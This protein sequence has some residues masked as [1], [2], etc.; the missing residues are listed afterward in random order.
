MEAEEK[1]Q[2][3]IP[4]IDLRGLDRTQSGSQLWDS[5]RSEV[6]AAMEMYGCFEAVFDRASEELKEALFGKAMVDLFGLPLETKQSN[7]SAKPYLGYIG[8]IPGMDYESLRVE[9]APNLESVEKFARLL[10]PKGNP[11]FCNTVCTYAKHLQELEQMIGRMVLQ[12]MGL[13]KHYVSHIESLEYS[14]RLS[15]YGV[16]LDQET[17]I[18]MR[19]HLDPTMITIVCQHQVGGLEVQTK[20][21]EWIHVQPSPNSFTVV[22]G[23]AFAVLTNGRL[24]PCLHRVRPTSNCKRYSALFSSQP[25]D[26]CIVETLQELVDEQHPLLYKPCNYVDYLRFRFSADGRKAKN[27][28]KAFCGVAGEETEA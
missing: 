12:S 3:Q 19:P 20:D 27:K 2:L 8:Q 11:S 4:K 10:W 28:L 6:M 14:V 23:E 15:Q 25:R 13:E 17:K 18:A 21:G 5:I 1:Q 22:V 16:P 9:D 24:Q 7:S 26:G